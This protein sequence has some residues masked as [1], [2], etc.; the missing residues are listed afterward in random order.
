MKI[1][2]KQKS[3]LSK[4]EEKGKRRLYEAMFLI[5]SAEAAADWEGVNSTIQK[6]LEKA[7]VEIV[8]MR[9]WDDRRLAYDINGKE[10]GTYVLC[11]FNAEGKK[12]RD[13][14]RDVR[15]SERIMR[16]LILCAERQGMQDTK[17]ASESREKDEAKSQEDA[18]VEGSG[19]D[20]QEE[21][22]EQEADDLL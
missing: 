7:G 16:V 11:Y 18:S 21:D 13:I 6:M 5:D 12:I 19:E 1:K 22:S 2:S 17:R 9:K 10:K 4:K 15:L 14:E 8:S 20:E 3:P